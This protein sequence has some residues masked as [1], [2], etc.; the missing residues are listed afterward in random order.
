MFKRP[1]K[2]PN[3]DQIE[4]D[5]RHFWDNEQIFQKL[6]ERNTGGERFSFVDGP[7]TANNPMGVHHAWGRTYKDA[8]QRF[9]GLRGYDQRFQN[10]F[11]CQ[12][13]WVEVEAE[14]D[15]GLNSKREIED[16]GLDN[17]S[18]ACKN[19]VETYSKRITEQSKRLGMWMDWD[20]SYFTH[21][22]ANVEHIWAFLKQCHQNGWLKQ[23]GRVMPWCM[24]C[25][26]S[27]SQHELLGTDTYQ[28]LTHKAVTLRLP[29]RGRSNEFILVWT[30]TAWTLAG[31][32]ACAV[33]S[34]LDYQ[35]VEKDGSVYYLS[36][37]TTDRVLDDSFTRVETLKGS[38][39]VGWQY[40]GPWDELPAQSDVVHQI[41]NWEDV[42]EEEGTGIVHIAP[43]SG[44]E[45]YELGHQEG[46]PVIVPI[47]G[48]GKYLEGF[49]G[50]T[51]SHVLDAVDFILDNMA[52]KKY[53]FNAE[54]YTHRYPVCWRCKEEIV[55]NFVDEWFISSNEIRP[56]MIA[57]SASVNWVPSSAGKRMQDWLENMGDWAI[58]RKRYWGL[59]LP[60]YLCNDSNCGSLTVIGSR[61]EL[62]TSALNTAEVDLLPELHRPWIDNIEIHCHSCGSPSHR[63]P[64]V[65]DCWLDAGI[66]PFSTLDY[67]YEDQTRDD[68][69][70]KKWFPATFITEMR[71]Q[72]R[73]WFYSMLFMSVTLEDRAP[74]KNCF[75]YEKVM[76]EQGNAMHRSFGNAID[77]DEAVDQMGA[78]V[79]RWLYLGTNP[80]TNVKFG[81][82]PA[83]EVVRKLLTL[84]NIYSFFLTYAEL[85]GFDPTGPKVPVKNR[86]AMDRWVLSRVEELREL[87]EQGYENY[88]I[89]PLV[90]EIE[91]FWDDLS[92][93]Y[94]RLNRRR[95]WKSQAD[96]DKQ[97]AYATLYE[98]LESLATLISPLMPFLAEKIYQDVVVPA[99]KDAP[100]SVFLNP[101]KES[102]SYERDQTL[103]SEMQTVR[104]VVGLGRAARSASGIKARQPLSEL[105]LGLPREEDRAAIENHMSIVLDEINVKSVR[106]VKTG[107]DLLTY[108]LKPNYRKLGPRLGDQVRA[109]A[110]AIEQ[111]Q[112]EET[113]TKLESGDSITLEIDGAKL[114][115]RLEDIDL[116]HKGIDGYAVSSEGGMVAGIALDISPDLELEGFSR[117]VIHAV[118][119]VRRSA[120][121]DV[122]DRISLRLS[123]AKIEGLLAVFG[124]HLKSEVLAEEL[125]I[126]ESPVH[127][128][129]EETVRLGKS[130]VTIGIRKTT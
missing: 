101:W 87:T 2:N 117:E 27:L 108:E 55:F 78:D 6:V 37:G 124:D 95:F 91:T 111:L 121:L 69:K 30:T 60:F 100:I 40:C 79:T 36:A 89:Y 126:G 82:T 102:G 96:A 72:I 18:K 74:Y 46:L 52:E 28:E 107:S 110:S 50:L 49:G 98:V 56:R 57:A 97:A 41:I 103:E 129:H 118:Q 61:E 127:I 20:N 43:G 10:G 26:T 92:N 81:F 109:A 66:V 67:L 14:R 115:L 42:S 128:D 13:L 119:N 35:K 8:Y 5:I 47:D 54:D 59:P 83:K 19:R 12:G 29:I 116:R 53:L 65:G 88:W 38:E 3:F 33:N 48:E 90:R 120:G 125:F 4:Q 15:L 7:I 75:V 22:D 99:N 62:R 24:R 58:S 114:V 23:G 68:T 25:G 70:W 39:L 130:E 77:F 122:S 1:D 63:V 112:P 85:D 51:G 76:D 17:F 105:A 84:W 73:L 94:V 71:E 21:S 45:D 93:W 9:W 32:V 104:Q 31:N 44:A 16:F 34:D 106:F 113:A 11:D 80:A 123:G 64:E 86:P